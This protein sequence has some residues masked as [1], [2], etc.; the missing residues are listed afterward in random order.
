MNFFL[1][2][3]NANPFVSSLERLKYVLVKEFL[4]LICMP[5]LHIEA[6]SRRCNGSAIVL[7]CALSLSEKRVFDPQ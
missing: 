1:T 2:K 6:L 4:L 5:S 7:A 3:L